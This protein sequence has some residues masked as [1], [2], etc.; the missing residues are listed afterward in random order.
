[1]GPATE[2][3]SLAAPARVPLPAAEVYY[4]ARLELPATP[5]ALLDELVR[6]T[7]WRQ[8]EVVIFGRRHAQPRLVAWYGDPGAI[9]AYSGITLSPLAWTERLAELRAL[10]AEVAGEAFNSVLVNY[11]RDNADSIGLHAD[12]EPELGPRPT[13]ASLSLGAER[14]LTFRPRAADGRSPVKLVLGSG[15]LLIMKGDTQ[16]NWNHGVAK[17]RRPLGPRVNL[18]FRRILPRQD[19][20][21]R[22]I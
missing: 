20:V 22:P 6:L 8:E 4:L 11:Y 10:A 1:V 21:A 12:D 7:P 2:R 15:S 17:E 9:Y 18:T 14:A 16:A 3:R 13:I 5:E 19:L